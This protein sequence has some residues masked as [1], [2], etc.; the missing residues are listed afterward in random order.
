MVFDLANGKTSRHE[1]NEEVQEECSVGEAA[2]SSTLS[3]NSL[4]CTVLGECWP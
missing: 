2:L 4:P 3:Q 1:E